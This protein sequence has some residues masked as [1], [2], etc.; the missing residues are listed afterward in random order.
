[1]QTGPDSLL[2]PTLQPEAFTGAQYQHPPV[3]RRPLELAAADRIR[4]RRALLFGHAH[5]PH[6]ACRTGRLARRADSRA[7][8]H[9]ALRV[10]GHGLGRRILGNQA[11]CHLPQR[12]NVSHPGQILAESEHTAEHPLHVGVQNRAAFTETERRNRRRRG[13]TDSWQGGQLGTAAWKLASMDTAHLLGAAQ[14]VACT[15][16]IPQAGPQ[17]QHLV[18][19]RLRQR[20]HIRKSLQKTRVIAQHRHHLRLLQHH[21]RQP[22]PVRIPCL[23]PGQIVAAMAALPLHQTAK[24]YRADPIGNLCRTRIRTTLRTGHS[25]FLEPGSRHFLAARAYVG[26]SLPLP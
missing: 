23:L 24:K 5:A 26:G 25:R 8:I 15:A 1:M 16:V 22:D 2:R 9:Q 18:L 13:R 19:M 3:L 21:F 14:Q 20:P 17:G 12:T 6:R 11:V 4:Q 10:G 7:Q